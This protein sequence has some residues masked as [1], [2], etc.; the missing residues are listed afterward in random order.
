MNPLTYDQYYRIDT[1][2][3]L[4]SA[5]QRGWDRGATATDTSTKAAEKL[6]N[7]LYPDQPDL[8]AVCAYLYM[9]GADAKYAADR[10]LTRVM[11]ETARGVEDNTVEAHFRNDAHATTYARTLAD[12]GNYSAVYVVHGDEWHPITKTA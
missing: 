7:E 4:G 8:A 3:G 1:F 9:A 11:A 12:S 2:T 6:G 5:K 10:L